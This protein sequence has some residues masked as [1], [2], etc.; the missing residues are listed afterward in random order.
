MLNIIRRTC[1]SWI[2]SCSLLTSRHVKSTKTPPM[3]NSPLQVTETELAPVE[4]LLK[5]SEKTPAPTYLFKLWFVLTTRVRLLI[6]FR[7]PSIWI[8][9]VFRDLRDL[10]FPGFG[11]QRR[12][13]RFEWVEGQGDV[14]G[15]ILVMEYGYGYWGSFSGQGA[16]G[17][18]AVDGGLE[19]CIGALGPGVLWA[20]A[21]L[22]W[23][24]G[25]RRR[26]GGGGGER[27]A[28]GS[29]SCLLFLNWRLKVQVLLS[30]SGDRQ[31]SLGFINKPWRRR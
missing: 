16:M 22:A 15:S 1:C 10:S 7:V 3:K 21:A 20:E 31:R 28:G 4:L 2:W 18:G 27:R 8:V 24:C 23:D 30:L 19:G 13:R 29:C 17:V 9:W 11:W 14:V 5:L 25:D 12:W 26:G 6:H